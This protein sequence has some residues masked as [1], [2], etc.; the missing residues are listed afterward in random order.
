MEGSEN[1]I[2]ELH[3]KVS[4]LETGVT[5]LLSSQKEI[6]SKLDKITRWQDEHAKADEVRFDEVERK[7]DKTAWKLGAFLGGSLLVAQ[8]VGQYVI[9]FFR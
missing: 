7:V 1:K 6:L 5:S 9:D 4:S 3:G 2:Y 8:T